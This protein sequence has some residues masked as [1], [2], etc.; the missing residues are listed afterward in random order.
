MRVK[1]E[2]FKVV[3]DCCGQTFH[4]DED[5]TC[6]CD[7]SSQ[8]E[9]EAMD[10]GW[11]RTNDGHHYCPD[12]HTLN[13]EDQWECEDGRKYDYDGDE[14]VE[15]RDIPYWSGYMANNLGEILDKQSYKVLVQYPQKNGYVNVWLKRGD[16]IKSMPVHRLVC[17]AFHGEEGYIN[18]L[19]VDHKD[20]NRANNRADNLHWVTP[21][22]NMNNPNTL[23]KR[24]KI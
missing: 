21:K 4:N 20:T 3:C 19:L 11:L 17:M 15:W 14:V 9:N 13:D 6:Y 1:V 10:S 18:G 23:S 8:I 12:C 7:H 24:K 5:F 2:T 22:E 16:N